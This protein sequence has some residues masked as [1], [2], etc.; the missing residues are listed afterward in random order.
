[1][2]CWMFMLKRQDWLQYPSQ[3]THFIL[4]SN[5]IRLKR[6]LEVTLFNT[7]PNAKCTVLLFTFKKLVWL[8]K[9]A[10]NKERSLYLVSIG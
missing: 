5:Y 6:K 8:S 2:S 9:D 1:M 3:S 4:M 10:F 7:G